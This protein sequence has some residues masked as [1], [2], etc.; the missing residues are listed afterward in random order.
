VEER[1]QACECD[2]VNLERKSMSFFN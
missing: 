1:I 2:N